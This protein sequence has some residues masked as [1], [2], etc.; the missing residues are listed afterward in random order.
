MTGDKLDSEL[1]QKK[2]GTTDYVN[3]PHK[4]E[5]TQYL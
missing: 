3:F 1:I 5:E 2:P 4:L